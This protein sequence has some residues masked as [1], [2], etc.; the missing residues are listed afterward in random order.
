MAAILLYRNPDCARCARL[1]RIHRALDWLNR[2]EDTTSPPPAGALGLGEIAVQDLASGQT[3]QGVEFFRLLCRN[4]PAYWLFLPL[5]HL[6][7]FRRYVERQVGG[8]GGTSCEG[9]PSGGR[10]A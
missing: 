7:P 6:A 9:P 3:L 2:F 5:L 1:S 8:C 10:R 4:I